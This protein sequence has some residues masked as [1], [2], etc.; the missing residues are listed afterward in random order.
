MRYRM[1]MLS[2]IYFFQNGDRGEE[3]NFIGR[4]SEETW[5]ISRFDTPVGPTLEHQFGKFAVTFGDRSCQTASQV[6]LSGPVGSRATF[7]ATQTHELRAMP[8]AWLR[9]RLEIQAE[10]ISLWLSSHE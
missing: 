3:N 2:H 10:A 9:A 1:M 7:F 5:I 8:K 6:V 4:R